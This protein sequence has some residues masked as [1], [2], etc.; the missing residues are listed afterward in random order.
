MSKEAFAKKH[1]QSRLGEPAEVGNYARGGRNA[2]RCMGTAGTRGGI[3]TGEGPGD[4]RDV[5]SDSTFTPKRQREERRVRDET[6]FAFRRVQKEDQRKRRKRGRGA[7]RKRV[8]KELRVCV[9]VWVWVGGDSATYQNGLC[10]KEAG[11]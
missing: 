11:C 10:H 4:V 8:S 5:V 2:T 3:V 6:W 7:T 1:R 9:C